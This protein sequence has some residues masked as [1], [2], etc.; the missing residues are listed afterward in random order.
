MSAV[1]RVK[2][3]GSTP[4]ADANT[5][6]LFTTVTGTAPNSEIGQDFFAIAGIRKFHLLLKFSQAGTLK[7]YESTDRGVNWRQIGQE[8]VA[9]P[10][11]TADIERDYI[12]EALRDFKIEWVNGGVAQSPWDPLMA[13]DSQRAQF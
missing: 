1:P 11:A 7:W 13:L 9:A 6:T 5:Y 8:A 12:V 10:A 3:T 2:Y 4:G